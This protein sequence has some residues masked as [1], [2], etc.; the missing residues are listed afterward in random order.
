MT[1]VKPN[2][3]TKSMTDIYALILAGGQG[4]RL[5]PLSRKNL[6]KQFLTFSQNKRSMLQDTTRRTVNLIGS[7]ENILVVSLAD[8]ANLVQ[9]QLPDLPTSNLLLEPVSRNTAASIGLGALTIHQRNREAAM[10]VLPADHIYPDEKTWAETIICAVDYA[11]NHEALVAIGITPSEASSKYGYLQLGNK[12][13]T[14]TKYPIYEVNQ[15][16]EKPEQKQAVL[17]IHDPRYIWNTGTYAWKISSFLK[18]LKIRL[19]QSYDLLECIAQ[20]STCMVDLYPKLENISIDYG[21]MEKT[22]DL[23]AVKGNFKRI[24][25]GNLVSLAQFLPEDEQSNALYGQV[26]SKNS[27]NNIAYT[28]EGLLGLI[29]VENMIVIRHQDIVLVC[30]KSEVD[31]V[32]ELLFSLDEQGFGQYK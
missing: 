31:R 26:L 28:D 21:V 22:L 18:E 29:G 27:T 30:P 3:T 5:W 23:V 15:F 14:G 25:I 17:Y 6:P 11:H 8:Q 20:D 32:K 24:D 4:T 9:Q 10:L 13:N 7:W 19:P 1:L 16:I 2:D 12:L